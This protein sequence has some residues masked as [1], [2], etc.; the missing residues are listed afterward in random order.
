MVAER[1]IMH[2]ISCPLIVSNITLQ[3]QLL[4]V[5]TPV[6]HLQDDFKFRNNLQIAQVRVMSEWNKVKGLIRSI[7]QNPPWRVGSRS[8]A[9]YWT[10]KFV[11][12][13]T[14]TWF[15]ILNHV[16][17]FTPYLFKF[18]FNIILW[19]TARFPQV[20][21]FFQMFL[22]ENAQLWPR[23]STQRAARLVKYCRTRSRFHACYEL[24]HPSSTLCCSYA[25][26]RTVAHIIILRWSH[27]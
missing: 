22:V 26:S 16:H 12:D 5:R 1:K 25:T 15:I 27:K 17:T 7:E 13:Y 20:V 18:H 24:T 6:L 11:T 23:A 21:S 4:C 10:Q 9:F 2:L 19:S 14:E 8:S 3:L